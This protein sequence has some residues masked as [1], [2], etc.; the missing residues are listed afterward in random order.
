MPWLDVELV[1]TN[2]SISVK[3][4]SMRGENKMNKLC[5]QLK[6]F[7]QFEQFQILGMPEISSLVRIVRAAI[8]AATSGAAL[9]RAR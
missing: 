9:A 6:Q 1:I 4:V 2:R 5:K 7:K 8:G 3:I